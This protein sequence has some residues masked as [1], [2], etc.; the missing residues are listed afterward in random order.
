MES[1]RSKGAREHEALSYDGAD[2]KGVRE[3]AGMRTWSNPGER[4]DDSSLGGRG[5]TL[6]WLEYEGKHG[7]LVALIFRCL[8]C[9]ALSRATPARFESDRV[10]G[11]SWMHPR[12]SWSHYDH[13]LGAGPTC[14]GIA[15]KAGACAINRLAA[16]GVESSCAMHGSWSSV[17]R[18]PYGMPT[19]SCGPSSGR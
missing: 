1:C 8:R 19:P 2:H 5:S 14:L 9:Y 15:A 11:Q 16:H 3:K 13:E 6:T 17:G 4:S 10:R 12:L 18:P 7:M